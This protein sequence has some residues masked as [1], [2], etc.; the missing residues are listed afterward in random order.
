[1]HGNGVTWIDE[2]EGEGH[3]NALS[4]KKLMHAATTTYKSIATRFT[5]CI[6]HL[7]ITAINVI[8]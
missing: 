8:G 5:R 1:M 4:W 2:L 6:E 3:C 7:L